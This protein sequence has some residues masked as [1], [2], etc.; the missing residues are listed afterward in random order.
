MVTDEHGCVDSSS[1]QDL[2]EGGNVSTSTVH[3]GKS[4]QDTVQYRVP[5]HLLH[6]CT[7]E[8]TQAVRLRQRKIFSNGITRKAEIRSHSTLVLPSKT[9]IG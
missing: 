2:N 7:Y 3:I 4:L 1:T 8:H 6:V 5:T 9:P